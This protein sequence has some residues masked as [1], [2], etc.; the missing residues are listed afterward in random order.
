MSRLAKENPE[1]NEQELNDLALRGGNRKVAQQGEVRYDFT[2]Y[3]CG[4]EYTV[5][6]KTH[7]W[8]Q[9]LERSPK[10]SDCYL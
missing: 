10:C 5:D 9:S 1:L 8:I 4:G 3:K 6:Q 7:E 2:C